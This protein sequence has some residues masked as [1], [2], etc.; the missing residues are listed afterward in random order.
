M[1][2]TQIEKAQLELLK[3]H[4]FEKAQVKEKF[5]EKSTNWLFH[6]ELPSYE[7]FSAEKVE[8]EII[9]PYIE[10]Y[11]PYSREPNNFLEWYIGVLH[12]VGYDQKKLEAG[13]VSQHKMSHHLSKIQNMSTTGSVVDFLNGRGQNSDF[14]S[15]KKLYERTFGKNDVYKGTAAQNIRLLS[16]LKNEAGLN[17]SFWGE[18]SGN[19]SGAGRQSVSKTNLANTGGSGSFQ[20]SGLGN[21]FNFG[22]SGSSYSPSTTKSSSSLSMVGSNL[23]VSN[24]EGKPSLFSDKYSRVQNSIG[25]S[26][27]MN[28]SKNESIA[29][30]VKNQPSSINN[31]MRN[32]TENSNLNS[33]EKL[34]SS[35]GNFSNDGNTEKFSSN[36]PVNLQNNIGAS[37]ENEAISPTQMN[38][39]ESSLN[40]NEALNN[41]SGTDVGNDNINNSLPNNDVLSDDDNTGESPLSASGQINPQEQIL[42]DPN[43]ESSDE[44]QDK[45]MP[46]S[47][48]GSVNP[49]AQNMSS[50]EDAFNY[51]QQPED[52]GSEPNTFYSDDFGDEGEDDNFVIY[53]DE[54]EESDIH[55]SY[56]N[57]LM[58]NNY[59]LQMDLGI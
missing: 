29:S 44:N 34:S 32:E 26:S 14:S 18:N 28:Q 27:N 58:N 24:S 19:F 54:S 40:S 22:Q 37:S 31:V 16:H 47:S 59:L 39:N 11:N 2:I 17:S 6:E 36:T 13:E 3:E 21:S 55:D 20:A 15:R 1:D 5:G 33:N 51:S 12:T 56:D 49:V 50:A 41:E 35:G 23:N 30:S 52:E 10:K 46:L 9:H 25:P 7:W 38:I 8:Q 43:L 48:P 57:E 53:E 4:I 42:T 45:G